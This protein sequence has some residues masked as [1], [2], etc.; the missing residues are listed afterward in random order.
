MDDER[1]EKLYAKAE[2]LLSQATKELYKPK[3]DV[4]TY[5]AC[6]SARSAL[7]HFLGTFYV[8]KSTEEVDKS[9]EEGK[10]T[11]DELI[12]YADQHISN[13]GDINFSCMQCT[14]QDV[15]KIVND[16][17]I[18]FCNSVGTVKECTDLAKKVKDVLIQDA[19]GG[20]APTGKHTTE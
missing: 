14:C 7:Y 17:E 11:I 4:V 8:Y 20:Q 19:F 10:M 9:L 3:E 5:S 15:K 18:Y 2:K 6:I 1:V 12:K 13:I 16:D